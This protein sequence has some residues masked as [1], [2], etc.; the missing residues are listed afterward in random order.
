MAD[1]GLFH[2]GHGD[3]ASQQARLAYWTRA[4][5]TLD[6]IPFEEL[7]P[8]EKVNAQVFRASIRALAN[9]VRFR[10][11]EAPFNSDTFFWTEFTPRQGLATAA[12]YRSYLA[13]LRDVPRYFDEQIA[14]MRAG[15]ARGFTVPREASSTQVATGTSV[16][17]ALLWT[18]I[19]LAIALGVCTPWALAL[20]RAHP[21]AIAGMF[22]SEV[23]KRGAEAQE[24][25]SGPPGFYFVSFWLTAFPWC[26]FWP[27]AIWHGWKR[28]Q[29]PWVR[30]CLAAVVGPFDATVRTEEIVVR[31]PRCGTVHCRVLRA[32]GTPAA[33][34]FVNLAPQ[35]VVDHFGRAWQGEADQDGCIEFTE[36]T[37]GA[38]KVLARATARVEPG[39]VGDTVV[40][41]EQTST[42]KLVLPDA[43][44]DFVFSVMGEEFG[45]VVALFI[46]AVFCFVILRGIARLMN[47]QNIFVLLAAAGLL[48]SFGLQAA[49]NMASSLS[50]IPTKGMT[51]PF[52]SYGGS[53]YLALA[54]AM[55]M[56]LE[57]TRR[58]P[59][60]A[61]AL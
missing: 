2:L 24:G 35:P 26:L 42:V 18:L 58:R 55:G 29:I 28:R 39:A 9:D 33:N 59:A 31:L 12:A 60:G 23:V 34:A 50:M 52:I 44:S 19:E 49:I 46:V 20:E 1:D 30:F 51:L 14:N 13:R 5:A 22:M 8:E 36:V 15:L 47:E 3:A 56:V 7:S 53:S 40:H 17:K 37:P 11:Y 16:P 57:L 45:T 27:A 10:T 21:G 43:H 41:P 25:H 54:I 48:V 38:Y 61:E 6:S 32:D 4:L